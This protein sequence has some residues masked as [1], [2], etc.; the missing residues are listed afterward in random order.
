MRTALD[1]KGCY[2]TGN[3][4]A[5]W[6]GENNELFSKAK[7]S[8][9]FDL[10]RSVFRQGGEGKERGR[11]GGGVGKTNK[12]QVVEEQGGRDKSKETILVK[13]D[14]KK[15]KVKRRSK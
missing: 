15:R 14:S 10:F 13:K 6:I 9:N 4:K 11:A 1:Y 3:K 12:G 5:P 7:T 8:R 2:G